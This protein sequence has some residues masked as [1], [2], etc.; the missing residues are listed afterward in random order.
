M[1]ICCFPSSPPPLHR[2]HPRAHLQL[3]SNHTSSPDQAVQ[4]G[5]FAL[6][7]LDFPLIFIRN[8]ASQLASLLPSKASYAAHKPTF[9]LTQDKCARL[10]AGIKGLLSPLSSSFVAFLD[11]LGF[12]FGVFHIRIG[13]RGVAKKNRWGRDSAVFTVASNKSEVQPQRGLLA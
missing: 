6:G 3:H 13:G 9:L 7:L 11:P 1:H 10:M 12:F 4:K 8:V 2:S 5:L